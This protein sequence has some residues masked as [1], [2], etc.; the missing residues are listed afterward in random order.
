MDIR[1][2]L[3]NEINRHSCPVCLAV[4]I[5]FDHEGKTGI[6]RLG[7]VEPSDCPEC[8]TIDHNIETDSS[9]IVSSERW[10]R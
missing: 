8:R 1:Y 2:A 9:F 5:V 3:D 4:W 10:F 6:Y 7:Q